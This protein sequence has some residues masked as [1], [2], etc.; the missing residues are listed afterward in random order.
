MEKDKVIELEDARKRMKLKFES[1]EEKAEYEANI[2]L[3]NAQEIYD[4]LN[5][6]K[7][8]VHFREVVCEYTDIFLSLLN[9]Y[10][11]DNIESLYEETKNRTLIFL[12]D[13]RD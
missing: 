13:R 8:K 3:S 12:L 2:I 9:Q 7:I 11:P 1:L 5:D 6:N 4:I 10:G